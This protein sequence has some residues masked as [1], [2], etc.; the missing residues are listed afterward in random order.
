MSKRKSLI[1]IITI[2]V[3]FILIGCNATLKQPSEN[4]H[5]D[6]NNKVVSK[7]SARSEY[8]K[9]IKNDRKEKIN[10][11]DQ[12]HLE[13][14]NDTTTKKV[15]VDSKQI[16]N[17]TDKEIQN[18]K[19][20]RNMHKPVDNLSYNKQKSDKKV[21]PKKPKVKDK[22]VITENKNKE[23]QKPIE[24]TARPEETILP[25]AIENK[26]EVESKE[27]EEEPD[28]VLCKN[29]WFDESKPCNYIPR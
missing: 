10:T 1:L 9:I 13:K 23:A 26:T 6:T 11:N 24:E 3:S 2:I 16:T 21:I 14:E 22:P 20:I 7:K 17:Q 25:E 27:P 19:V 15:T 5:R 12:I 8:N 29:A 28:N 4:E 18:K